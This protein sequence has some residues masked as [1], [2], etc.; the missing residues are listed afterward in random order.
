MGGPGGASAA[1]SS[2]STG[3]N[4][5]IRARGHRSDNGAL[6]GARG[7]N[8]WGSEIKTLTG[9]PTRQVQSRSGFVQ[10]PQVYSFELGLLRVSVLHRLDSYLTSELSQDAESSVSTS[11]RKI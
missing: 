2:P 9:R 8:G 11:R 7:M 10:F 3:R 4:G 1:A 6:G 5:A